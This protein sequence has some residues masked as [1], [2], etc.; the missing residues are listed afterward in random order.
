MANIDLINL[1]QAGEPLNGA[2]SPIP[3]ETD[4]LNRPIIEM[5][6]LMEQGKFDIYS[7]KQSIKLVDNNDFEASVLSE[8]VVSLD[9]LTGKFSK[10]IP[11]QISVMG[12]ADLTNSIVHSFGVKTFTTYTF[13]QGTYYYLS[14]SLPGVI[15]PSTSTDKSQVVI[16]AAISTTKLYVGITYETALESDSAAMA[17]ALGG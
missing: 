3:G 4:R 15:V 8:Q 7:T 6:D 1:F 9:P 2:N 11:S 10:A 12:I 13:V 14:K 5:I 17:I 16:G